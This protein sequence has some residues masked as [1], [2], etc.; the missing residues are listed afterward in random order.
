[1]PTTDQQANGAVEQLQRWET[2]GAVWRVIARNQSSATVGL[3]RCDGGEEVE[4]ITS[5]D[6]DL[7]EYLASRQSSD[8]LP[9]DRLP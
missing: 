8:A 7:L 9:P 6:P 4:R 3:F 2:A 5:S 1:M